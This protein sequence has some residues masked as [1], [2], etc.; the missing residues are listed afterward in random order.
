MIFVAAVVAAVV[1]VDP[2]EGFPLVLFYQMVIFCMDLQECYQFLFL[3][4]QLKDQHHKLAV[5]SFDNQVHQQVILLLLLD[6]YMLDFFYQYQTVLLRVSQLFSLE[7]MYIFS[8]TFLF[9]KRLSLRPHQ[10]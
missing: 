2:F 6:F 10:F 3:E 4:L 5:V 8:L 7:I 9:L 1:V